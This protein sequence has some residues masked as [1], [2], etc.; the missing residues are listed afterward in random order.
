[1]TNYTVDDK[2]KTQMIW[3]I[4]QAKNVSLLLQWQVE[5]FTNLME[6][7]LIRNSDEEIRTHTQC[8]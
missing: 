4:Y 2:L 7:H 8:V 5:V 3:S 1:M 6:N